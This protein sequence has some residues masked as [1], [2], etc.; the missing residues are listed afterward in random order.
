MGAVYNARRFARHL[1]STT[2]IS[3]TSKRSVTA[4]GGLYTDEGSSDIVMENNL[5][6]RCK[7][8]NFHQHYGKE[9]RV[10]NKH[11]RLRHRVATPA[12]PVG[13]AHLVLLRAETSCTGTMP[14]SF[15]ANNWWDN[16]FKFDHNVYWNSAGK[17]IKFF[18][19]FTF[20]K[21][22][23]RGQDQHSIVADPRF[24]APEKNDFRLKDNSPALAVGFKPFDV[25]KAGRTARA[26]LT[27]DLPPVPRAFDDVTVKK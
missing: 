21:W 10:Q 23:Q 1:G 13:A 3:T 14:A 2:I 5:V 11:L 20:P 19:D 7:S 17:P 6:Y 12:D 8:S 4:A 16:H 25:S 26:Q 18:A 24:V 22:Q 9:N 27:R 15:W